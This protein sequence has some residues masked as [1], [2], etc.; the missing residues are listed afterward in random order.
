MKKLAFI[1]EPRKHKALKFV[2]ENFLSI[3]PQEW[4]IQI[5]H[6]TNN[7]NYIVNIIDSSEIIREAKLKNRLLLHD[8]NVPNLTHKGESDL[9]RTEDFWD[10]LDADLLLKFECDTILCPNSKYKI[11]D[12]EKFDYIGGYWGNRLYHPLDKPYPHLKPNGAYHAPYKGP[13]VLP[14]NGALSLRNKKVMKDLVYKY[15]DEYLEAGKPYS[16]DYFFSEYVKKPTTREVISFS[17]DNGY[18]APLNGEAPFGIHKPWANKGGA[19][20]SIKA[21]CKEVEILESLQVIEE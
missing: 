17:I 12:F 15:Y 20:S 13:Q 18:I 19:Y 1:T 21:V 8:L 6:G 9:L 2:L 10:I 3:L 5:N 16:E 7:L 4:N 11:S 14:M